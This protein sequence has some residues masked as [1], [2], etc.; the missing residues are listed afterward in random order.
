VNK[1][2]AIVFICLGVAVCYALLSALM[3]VITG[4]TGDVSAN[5]SAAHDMSRYVGAKEG[6]D[7][8]PWILYLLPGGVG[9]VAIVV[10]LRQP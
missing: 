9:I 4:V 7:V 3:P 6:L 1:V 8:A 5:I 2:K 10:I